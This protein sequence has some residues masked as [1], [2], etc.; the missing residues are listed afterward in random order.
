MK[1]VDRSHWYFLIPLF[2]LVILGIYQCF[3]M[4]HAI[5]A[6]DRVQWLYDPAAPGDSATVRNDTLNAMALKAIK[7]VAVKTDTL[8]GSLSSVAILDDTL[9]LN[10]DSTNCVMVVWFTGTGAGIKYN[11]TTDSLYWTRDGSTWVQFGTGGGGAGTGDIDAV[12]AGSGLTGGGTSGSVTIDVITGWGLRIHND[13]VKIN[14]TQLLDSAVILD[15]DS[16]FAAHRSSRWLPYPGVS[17]QSVGNPN[18][19]GFFEHVDSTSGNSYTRSWTPIWYWEIVPDS[20]LPTW[21]RVN[22]AIGSAG[23]GDITGVL[24]NDWITGSASS[25]DVSLG[26]NPSMLA[27]L[28]LGGDTTFVDGAFVK[29]AADTTFVLDLYRGVVTADSAY[30]TIAR[31]NAAIAASPA[32]DITNVGV[33]APIT[34]GGSSGSVTVGF[35][36]TWLYG[37]VDTTT[38]TIPRATLADSTS[39]GAARATTAKTADSTNGGAIRSET[40][41]LLLGAQGSANTFGRLTGDSLIVDTAFATRMNVTNLK[42]GSD[43]FITDITGTGLQI[44]TGALEATLGTAIV[45]GEI[46]DQTIIKDD[47]DSTSSNFAFDDAFHVTTGVADSEYTSLKTMRQTVTD[48][49]HLAQ[50]IANVWTITGN[51]INT[52]NPWAVNEGGTGAATFTQNGILY[53]NGTSAIGVTAQGASGTV[54]HGNAGTPT[55]SAVVTGDVTDGTLTGA[56]MATGTI[57]SV[58]LGPGSVKAAELDTTVTF[59]IGNLRTRAANQGLIQSNNFKATDPDSALKI[60][61]G[62][63]ITVGSDITLGTDISDDTTATIL[64]PEYA[65]ATIFTGAGAD[66]SSRQLTIS[67]DGS[68]TDNT[69][70]YGNFFQCLDNSDTTNATWQRRYI[71]IGIPVPWEADSIYRVEIAHRVFNGTDAESTYIIA[72]WALY[73]F[74]S[75]SVIAT[76]WKDSSN[77]TTYDTLI[78]GDHKA[79]VS[80]GQ[81]LWVLIGFASRDKHTTWGRTYNV[82]AIWHRK[83]L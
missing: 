82:Q 52:T 38:A 61:G 48:S 39:G 36:W 15:R 43:A 20:A 83:Y 56:D 47:L 45:S 4:A 49:I 13:S 71:Q 16:T 72:R 81:T 28:Y 63:G 25:G 27:A 22:A 14:A 1:Q 33:T 10:R 65:G 8:V 50:T 78:L 23:G 54:L 79:A 74:D 5:N 42:V 80:R 57:D 6:V 75:A 29:I 35:D 76:G 18:D 67:G 19:S 31:V 26:I 40:T 58:R 11:C 3:T 62:G 41:K 44:T 60:G 70:E 30:P 17:G 55:F 34:G 21:G 59:V 68:A 64:I 2:I 9:W 77:A 7:A 32:G 37:F 66:T 24:A 46:T 12:T 69:D 53:G 73:D 51:W